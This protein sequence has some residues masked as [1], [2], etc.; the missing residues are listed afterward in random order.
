ME[1]VVGVADV[2]V[3][4]VVLGVVVFVVVVGFVVVVVGAGVVVVVGVVVVA[5]VV[6]VVGCGW[7]RGSKEATKRASILCVAFSTLKKFDAFHCSD[8]PTY[9]QSTNQ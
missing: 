9:S 5:G 8:C 1:V 6:V 7:G 4:L 3:V 2:V